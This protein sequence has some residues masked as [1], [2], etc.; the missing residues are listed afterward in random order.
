MFK[1][2]DDLPDDVIGIE[3]SGKITHEDYI[4]NIIPHFESMFNTYGEIKLL[5]VLGDDF[6]GY[7]LGAL[8]DDATYGIRQWSNISHIAMI[9]DEQWPHS[10]ITMFA[11]LLPGEVKIYNRESLEE[12]KSWIKSKSELT[13]DK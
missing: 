3:A 10:M 9:A 4:N 2:M 6:D 13:S 1:I 7:E 11:P 12:A 8:W 5:Y